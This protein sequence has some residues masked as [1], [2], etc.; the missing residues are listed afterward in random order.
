[1]F[2][3]ENPFPELNATFKIA[4]NVAVGTDSTRLNVSYEDLTEE[5]HSFAFC[6][7][8]PYKTVSADASIEY[9]FTGY[10]KNYYYLTNASLT[11]TTSN[12]SLYL[13]NSSKA[14]LTVLKVY[15]TAQTNLENVTIQIQSY[16]V[17]TDTYYTVGMARTAFNGEDVAYLNWYDTFYKF[18]LTQG[19]TTVIKGPLKISET[20]QIF[21]IATATTFTFDKF[22]DFSYSLTYNN[23]TENFI[24]TYTKPSGLVDQA[25]L[26]VI[27]KGALNDTEIC[28]TCETS[29]SATLYCSIAGQGNGT[30]VAAFYATGSRFMVDTIETIVGIVG[31]SREMYEKIGNVDG[32]A[33]A[34]VGAGIALTLTLVSPVL[35]VVG[36]LIGLIGIYALGFQNYVALEFIGI[37]VVGGIVIWLLKR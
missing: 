19:N 29:S 22:R 25:C 11:N 4:W 37:V 28:L 12:I 20:P 36:V 18:I 31:F 21:E 16:D 17:G 13:L 5:N 30:Y 6:L 8:P 32:T 7:D 27:K 26:R 2:N 24:L 35:A 3:A 1:M 9:E 10:S 34:F 23:A 14:D 33:F 15:D